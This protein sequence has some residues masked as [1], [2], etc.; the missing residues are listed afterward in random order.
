MDSQSLLSLGVY[1]PGRFLVRVSVSS[2]ARISSLRTLVGD[3]RS[4]FLYNG[5]ILDDAMTFAFYRIRTMEAIVVVLSN[6]DVGRWVRQ[7]QEFDSFQER[8]QLIM[9]DHTTRE[10]ARIR[11]LLFIKME[12]RVRPFR[13]LCDAAE[14]WANRPSV[15]SSPP[16][17]IDYPRPDRP[18]CDP[19]P[20]AWAPA[21]VARRAVH[22]VGPAELIGEGE[23]AP[24]SPRPNSPPIEEES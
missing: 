10:A 14:S 8:I 12:R 24:R 23:A 5:Q 16:L 2:A 18:S 1:L 21:P 13:R 4:T 20:A 6:S 9:N 17:T 15:S 3:P 7:T 19:L 22:V 11:D